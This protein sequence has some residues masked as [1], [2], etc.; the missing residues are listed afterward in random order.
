MQKQK[1]YQI[2]IGKVKYQ[3]IVAVSMADALQQADYLIRK[4][5]PYNPHQL[6]YSVKEM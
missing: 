1:R 2:Y 5:K 3:K 4:E 6:P